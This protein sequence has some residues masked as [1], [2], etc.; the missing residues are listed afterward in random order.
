MSTLEPAGVF[1]AEAG[2]APFCVY[3]SVCGKVSVLFD[4][5]LI[6][7]RKIT[8]TQI[9]FFKEDSAMLTF[10]QKLNNYA[11]LAVKIGANVQPGQT[12]VVS[13][14]IEARELVRL[15]VK[16]LMKLGPIS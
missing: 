15:I 13:A 1:P 14:D 9:V 11:E 3:A 10:D 4:L 7:N 12:L 16:K 6:Y 5:W 2:K 8:Q